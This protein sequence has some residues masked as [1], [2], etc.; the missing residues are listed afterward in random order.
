[1]CFFG[2]GTPCL[3]NTTWP[4]NHFE[5]L[6]SDVSPFG[7]ILPLRARFFVHS[8][9]NEFAYHANLPVGDVPPQSSSPRGPS[10]E[11]AGLDLPGFWVSGGPSI[12]LQ[13]I[14]HFKFVFWPRP[15]NGHEM[16]LK[17]VSG[18]NFRSVLH[19]FSSLTHWSGSRGQVRPETDRKRP[20]LRLWFLFLGLIASESI[21]GDASVLRLPQPWRP[22]VVHRCTHGPGRRGSAPGPLACLRSGRV[23][24]RDPEVASWP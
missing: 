6:L 12:Y 16:T 3:Q 5:T 10:P 23:A 20:K 7:S 19:H 18:A 21:L 1:M 8:R 4:K 24:Q 14:R 13:S 9:I 17:L 22:L 15:G 11:P 2:L